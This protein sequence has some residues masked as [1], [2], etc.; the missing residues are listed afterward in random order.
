MS[1][2]TDPNHISLFNM[3]AL[4]QA[5]RLETLGMKKRGQSAYAIVK[6]HY[7]LRGNKQSVYTQFCEL[8]EKEKGNVGI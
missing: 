1:T 4:K 8:C 2:I 5:L 6:S 3:L 7:G